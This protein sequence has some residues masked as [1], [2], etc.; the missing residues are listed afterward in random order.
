M[1]LTDLL[2]FKDDGLI[3]EVLDVPPLS[4]SDLSYCS[5]R[6]HDTKVG[7]PIVLPHNGDGSL[8]VERQD[9]MRGVVSVDPRFT[10]SPQKVKLSG[11]F[12]V[13]NPSIVIDDHGRA[14][15]Y[16]M[17]GK[18]FKVDRQKVSFDVK[19]MIDA[20]GTIQRAEL[21]YHF[22]FPEMKI[23]SAGR[24]VIS[25]GETG[26]HSVTGAA[27]FVAVY[28]FNGRELQPLA[29]PV[30][31]DYMIHPDYSKTVGNLLNILG[32]TSLTYG[33]ID[34]LA[35]LRYFERKV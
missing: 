10:L 18:E 4:N 23:N 20:D 34:D 33:Q 24:F 8:Y 30:P 6:R 13:G 16:S 35:F 12:V 5:Y 19:H 26:E 17:V 31:W 1:V 32:S 3:G 22:G 21:R 2:K 9:K 11:N 29:M 7:I 28:V 15:F 25:R 27:L 14:C